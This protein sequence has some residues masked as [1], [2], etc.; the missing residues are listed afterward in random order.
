MTREV[1]L[2]SD[3]V[4]RGLTMVFKAGISSVLGE[5]PLAER[6][7]S[8]PSLIAPTTPWGLRS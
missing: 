4:L 8:G 5:D 1:A 7:K 3:L 6:D 2:V